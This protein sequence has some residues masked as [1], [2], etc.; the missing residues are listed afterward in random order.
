MTSEVLRSDSDSVCPHQKGHRTQTQTRAERTMWR[1]RHR[2]WAHTCICKSRATKEF[3]EPPGGQRGPSP[4]EPPCRHLDLGLLEPKTVMSSAKVPVCRTLSLLS[5]ESDARQSAPWVRPAQVPPGASVQMTVRWPLTDLKHPL[6]LSAW[7][8][9][10][11]SARLGTWAAEPP[12]TLIVGISQKFNDPGYSSL[13]QS[14]PKK[15]LPR[16]A[17]RWCGARPVPGT[18]CSSRPPH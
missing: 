6:G 17:V 13:I 18:P 4:G 14:L 5:R 8:W 16:A 12:L 9:P 1:H 7:L 15:T 10:S 3:W 2:G 11:G